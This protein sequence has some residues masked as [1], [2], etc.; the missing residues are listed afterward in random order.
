MEEATTDTPSPG[1]EALQDESAA[2]PAPARSFADAIA[3]GQVGLGVDIVEISR[4]KRILARTPRFA[5]KV[6]SEDERAYCETKVTPEVHYA[7]RF[8]AK[9]AVLK[10][11]GTGFSGGIGVR[12]I[13]VGRN[14]KGRPYVVLRG[15]AKELADTYGVLE[16]PLS[17][18]YTHRDAIAC[19]MAITAE[20]LKSSQERIDPMEELARQFKEA[21]NLLDEIGTAKEEAGGAAE[22][23]SKAGLEAEAAVEPGDEG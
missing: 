14:T 11:L 3:Q 4:M 7:T 21:R 10:A 12:D 15:R 16:V 23:E 5:G 17:L 9:E 2:T 22:E 19:A 8:A 18:S 6:F 13:E 20:S 1:E